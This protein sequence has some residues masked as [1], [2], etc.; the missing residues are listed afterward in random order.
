MKRKTHFRCLLFLWAAALS[1]SFAPAPATDG[2]AAATGIAD[3]A[4]K[5]KGETLTF[6]GAEVHTVGRMVRT[7]KT[8]P[9]FEAVNAALETV[10][11]SS[12]RG[13]KVV[14]NVFPSLDTPTCA[15]SVREFNAEAASMDSATVVLCLSMDLPFAQSR[16]CA[17][18]GL[19]RVVP[20][21]LFRSRGFG[22]AYGLTLAD[23]PLRGLTARAV[24]VIDAEGVVR[25]AQLVR[26]I[27]REPDYAAALQALRALGGD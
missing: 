6:R 7:G 17:A 11:L 10:Q 3:G 19:T 25:H 22:E 2:I 18:E 21:S 20:L 1:M 15:A 26:E 9:D 13:R 27:S 14:L 12:Y 5:T 23:G 24:L 16:F 8:A 4:R